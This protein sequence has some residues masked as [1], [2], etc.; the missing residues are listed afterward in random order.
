[1]A[2][3]PLNIPIRV[4][5][6]KKAK[7]QLSG[8]DNSIKSMGKS[9][10]KA[11][12]GFFAV[13]GLI[14]GLQKSIVLAGQFEKVEKGF[15]NLARQSGFSTQ[16]LSKL[17]RATDGTVSSMELMRQANNAMLLGIADSED[18]MAQM[19]DIAQRLGSALGQD[20]TFAVESLVTGLG[21]QS[22]LML[23]NLGIMV[24]VNKANEDYAETLGIS[25]NR[26]T[27]QQRKQ[28]FVNAAMASA[29]NLVGQLGSETLSASDHIQAMKAAL[30]ELSITFGTEFGDSVVKATNFVTKLVKQAGDLLREFKLG[31]PEAVEVLVGMAASAEKAA[32]SGNLA[33]I[34]SQIKVIK[35]TLIEIPAADTIFNPVLDKLQQSA[36]ALKNA[37]VHTTEMI[38][39]MQLT[40]DESRRFAEFTAQ[41]ATSLATSAIM[42]DNV[43]EAFKR[44]LMQQILITAQMK[45]QKSIQEAMAAMQFAT[46]GPM[47]WIGAGLKFLFGASPTQATPSP[48]VTINQNFGGMGVIDQ[49]FAAN[50][51]IPAINKAVSTGQARITK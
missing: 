51:I 29:N 10:L 14:T 42:G 33:L 37:S 24:D 31:G 49:N 7:Q 12:A 20:T 17:Q 30:E 15:Q 22:K 35:Q 11:G 21:R 43:A 47:G 45:I 4:K 39:T 28:A 6:G 26:L 50:S 18:Q 13:R 3:K 34:E 2:N 8:I 32:E 48:N 23:D 19:F 1:M 40:V 27:D 41:A 5:G 36:K 25:A 46:S 9:A 38:E 16:A 44:M